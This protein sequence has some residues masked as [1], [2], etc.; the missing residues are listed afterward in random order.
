MTRSLLAL[1]IAGAACVSVGR[2][3]RAPPV[4][5]PDLVQRGAMLFLS[6]SLSG[7]RSRSCA[8]CH[9]GGGTDGRVYR[10]GDEVPPGTADGRDTPPLWG[11][12]ATAPYRADGSA[13]SLEEL[14]PE[15]M[16][17]EMRGGEIG[18]LD[19]RALETYLLSLRPF[20]RGRVT[21][22][23]VPVEPATKSAIEGFDVFRDSGCV[24]CHPPPFYV[25]DKTVDVGTGGRFAVPSLRGLSQTPPYGHDG[26]WAT[27]EEA[28]RGILAGRGEELSRR[29]LRRLLAYLEL[30]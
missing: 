30:L 5:D 18:D 9:P 19:R 12:W 7:D 11:L 17:V 3:P 13:A 4:L 6:P 29:D 25:S 14:I 2:A 21:E 15:L 28:V 8:T 20:D 27:V 1:L 10:D 16:R 26:R 23:G 22:E 24:R